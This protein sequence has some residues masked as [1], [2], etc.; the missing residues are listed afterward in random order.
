MVPGVVQVGLFREIQI[1][2]NSYS[3]VRCANGGWNSKEGM[4]L[5]ITKGAHPIT[6]QA[7]DVVGAAWKAEVPAPNM[8][9]K[10]AEGEAPVFVS[11]APTPPGKDSIN[12]IE[13]DERLIE[14][15]FEV[16]LPPEEYYTMLRTKMGRRH[17]LAAPEVLDHL[18]SNEMLLDVATVSGFSFGLDKA[19]ILETRIKLLG[20]FI[21]REGRSST[22]EHTRAITQWPPITEIG[23]LRQFLGTVNWVRGHLPAEFS[24]ALKPVSPYLGKVEWPMPPWLEVPQ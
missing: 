22:K 2:P 23:Q 9:G 3:M 12:H 24:Q 8:W 17:P 10:K 21:D 18:L 14:R 19:Q 7:G 6:L 20:E 11:E 4:L 13:Q 16:E 5:I 15:M 1:L